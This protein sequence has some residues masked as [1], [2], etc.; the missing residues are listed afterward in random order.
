MI[1]TRELQKITRT[2]QRGSKEY[3]KARAE[4][5]KRGKRVLIE[6]FTGKEKE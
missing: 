6:T 2:M 1:T 3:K 4:L 5:K